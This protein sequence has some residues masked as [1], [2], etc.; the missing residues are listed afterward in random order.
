MTMNFMSAYDQLQPPERSFVD[1]FIRAVDI[2]NAQVFERLTVTLRRVTASI[3][4]SKMDERT[5]DQFAKPII[6]AAITQRIDEMARERDLTPERFV[7]EHSKIALSTI[8]A[9]F[10]TTGQDGFPQFDASLATP[11]DW[12]ALQ[13]IKVKETY[14]R[15]GTVREIDVKMHSKQPSIDAVMK[16]FGADQ[17]NNDVH[18][19][20]KAVEN[21]S[22][23]VSYDTVEDAYIEFMASV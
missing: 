22:S 20:Y 5:R 17:P 11:D 13:H 6:Q 3:D 19:R 16:W 15:S 9:F 18:K 8:K 12:A 21:N 23:T 2:E 14:G 7:Q 1:G 10:P 4:L